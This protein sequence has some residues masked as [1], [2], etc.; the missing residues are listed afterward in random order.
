[1]PTAGASRLT[2]LRASYGLRLTSAGRYRDL[3]HVLRS[4]DYHL[5]TVMRDIARQQHFK[6]AVVGAQPRPEC[7]ILS[8][9]KARD[10][11]VG[12][13]LY[14]MTCRSKL[15]SCRSASHLCAT[16]YMGKSVKPGELGVADQV[17]C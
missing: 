8:C 15:V 5:G 4:A 6:L 11:S 1:M 3:L 17:F 2:R 14:D 12:K 16:S 10:C 13:I 9:G 7:L